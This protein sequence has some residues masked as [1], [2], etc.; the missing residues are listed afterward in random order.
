MWVG[1]DEIKKHLNIDSDFTDDDEYLEGLISVAEGAISTHLDDGL[2][3]IA[4]VNGGVLPSPLAHA[5][6]LLVGNFYKNRES[7]SSLTQVELPFSF[8]YLMMLYKN[9]S[10]YD[11]R[12]INRKNCNS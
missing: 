10:A 4:S 9:Y 12:E 8:E 5:I 3:Y 11:C 2:D 6:K 1:I 7:V